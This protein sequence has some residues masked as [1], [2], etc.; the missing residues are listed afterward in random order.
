MNKFATVLGLSV[1][2][3][4][5]L[6]AQAPRDD[7]RPDDRQSVRRAERLTGTVVSVNRR[8]NYI[9]IRNDATRRNVKIDVRD[10]NTRR[11]VN[12]W[13]LRRGQRITVTGG[14]EDH[15]TFSA[16]TVNR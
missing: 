9:T 15:N 16:R 7:R 2:L 5:P 11:S 10:M 3:I 12:V 1:L 8:L 13:R 14:W 4:A 6:Y